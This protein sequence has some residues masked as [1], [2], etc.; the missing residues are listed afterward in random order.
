[1]V[2]GNSVM[3]VVLTKVLFPLISAFSQKGDSEGI[4]QV[5]QRLM[6]TSAPIGY[7]IFGVGLFV[8]IISA[9]G[10]IGAC[11]NSKIAFKS[12]TDFVE[13]LFLE[14]VHDYLNME[15]NDGNSLVVGFISP[16]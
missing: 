9:I 16:A 4:K 2:W 8:L 15:T 1:M 5:V 7:A 3:E 10:Y 6:T 13:D 11:F 12:A 14:C